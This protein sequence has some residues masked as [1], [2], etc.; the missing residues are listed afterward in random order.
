MNQIT[1]PKKIRTP[2]SA[3]SVN[4]PTSPVVECCMPEA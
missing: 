3:V 4:T 1:D 2:V